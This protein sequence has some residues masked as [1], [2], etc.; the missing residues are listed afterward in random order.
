MEKTDSN[1]VLQHGEKT[2]PN[3]VLQHGEVQH[4]EVQPRQGQHGEARN[5]GTDDPPRP[6]FDLW[7]ETWITLENL[8]GKLATL[9]LRD[10]LLQAHNYRTLYDSSPLVIVGVHRLLVAILQG[11]IAP[12]AESEL[13]EIAERGHFSADL[14]AE[15]ER[16]YGDRFDLFDPEAP[17][18]QSADIQLIPDKWGRNQSAGYLFHEEPPGTT[19]YFFNHRLDHK[20]VYCSVCAA[21]SL[22][23]LPAFTSAGGAG[24]K[25]SIN[26]VPP[27]YVLP[28]GENYFQS[29]L[30]SLTV[31]AYQPKPTRNIKPKNDLAWW[32]RPKPTIIGKNDELMEVGYLHSLTFPVRRV[33]LHPKAMSAPCTRCGNVTP[34]AVPEITFQM[35]EYRKAESFWQDPFAAYRVAK[36]ENEPPTAIRPVEGRATWREFAGLFL[37]RKQTGFRPSLIDQLE[38]DDLRSIRPK[39]NVQFQIVAL[40]TDMKMK[41]FEWE[42]S[43][44]TMP[45]ALLSDDNMGQVV[46]DGIDFAKQCEGVIFRVFGKHFGGNNLRQPRHAHLQQLLKQ[47]YWDRLG[48]P[49]RTEFILLLTPQNVDQQKEKWRKRCRDEAHDCFQE[50]IAYTGDDA[51]ALMRRVEAQ[52]HCYQALEKLLHPE[53]SADKPKKTKGGK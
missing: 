45:S 53:K 1:P 21:K 36:K 8:E 44:F 48:I 47:T 5:Q 10:T 16:R 40:R 43:G 12:E 2:H 24:N 33:R 41:M 15:F 3:P 51:E 14:I 9:S 39:R 18:M 28:V 27:I 49:F 25:A 20:I 23:T 11:M 30:F 22:T 32:R 13:V 35:G 26:G 6:T 42:L 4:R 50:I 37:P 52:N 19:P 46:E 38:H 17:F 7:R 29:L 34:F 31:Q